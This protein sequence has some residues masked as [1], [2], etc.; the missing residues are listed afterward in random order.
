MYNSRYNRQYFAKNILFYGHYHNLSKWPEGCM[1]V[2]RKAD[3][4]EQ[5]QDVLFRWQ[6]DAPPPP[7]NRGDNEPWQFVV[8]ESPNEKPQT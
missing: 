1:G 5:K 2:S 8:S 4:P 6:I 3:V 7:P